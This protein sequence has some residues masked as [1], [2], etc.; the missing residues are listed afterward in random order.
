MFV[1]SFKV[2]V[3][4]SW[5]ANLS[6]LFGRCLF[7]LLFFTKLFGLLCVDQVVLLQVFLV[8]AV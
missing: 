8:F 4:S 2:I 1:D 7:D 5:L 6:W 3:F